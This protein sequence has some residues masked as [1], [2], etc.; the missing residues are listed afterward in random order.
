MR[1]APRCI[2]Y[3]TKTIFNVSEYN[4]DTIAS[5]LRELSYLNAGIAITLT[6]LR[7]RDDE[8]N[9]QQQTFFS[10]GGLV[11]F[12]QYLD[13]TRESLIPEPIYIEGEKEWIPGT[14]SFEL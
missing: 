2:S 6:D 4:Y 1:L 13:S 10:E 3:L 9:Y 7:E 11:E 8:G 5:R 14:G 12:V